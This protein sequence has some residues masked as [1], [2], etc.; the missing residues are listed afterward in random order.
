MSARLAD[1]LGPELP[2]PTEAGIHPDNWFPRFPFYRK[3]DVSQIRQ[4][5]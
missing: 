5:A 3:L 4:L 2:F 1:G